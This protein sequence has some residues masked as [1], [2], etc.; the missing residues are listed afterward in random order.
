MNRP[1]IKDTHAPYRIEG[2]I[3]RIGGPV[4]GTAREITDKTGAIWEL[5]QAMDGTRTVD[6]I[7]GGVRGR[8]PLLTA[9]DVRDAIGVLARK[10]HVE[11]AAGPAPALYAKTMAR[12]AGDRH[13]YSW[14]DQEPRGNPW[15]WLERL[16]EAEVTIVGAGGS[17]CA[18]AEALVRA[19]IG[20][21]HLIDPDVVE[22]P[23]LSRQSLY[24][25]ADIGLPKLAAAIRR[26]GQ[27]DSACFISGEE[28]RVAGTED[29]AAVAAE[30]DVLLLAADDPAEIR[31]W[32]NRACWKTG[33]PWVNC[34]YCGPQVDV[35]SFV[36]G[37]GACQECLAAASAPHKPVVLASHPEDLTSRAIPPHPTCAVT[38][39]MS[40]L[41]A[42]WHVTARITGVPV[43]EAG[44]SDILNMLNPGRT[45]SVTAVRQPG[46][47]V[48]S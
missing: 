48:C 5:I 4:A 26:L 11:D 32:C 25:E 38:A 21:L 41:L 17:G 24:T 34:G 31:Q 6:E 22:L 7:A 28:I 40:G 1:K 46:C 13:L 10:G 44:R 30:C 15:Y 42:A 18:A 8:A 19:G 39:G 20:S 43:I 9:E 36:P 33:T 29:M 12:H 3:I 35:Q 47:E 45:R 23:N 27:I 16:R 14:I 2:G 37:E